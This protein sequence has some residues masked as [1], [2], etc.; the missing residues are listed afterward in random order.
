MSGFEDLFTNPSINVSNPTNMSSIF[1]NPTIDEI[2]NLLFNPVSNTTI[3]TQIDNSNE[4][5]KINTQTDEIITDS[6]GVGS[7]SPIDKTVS[8]VST[9]TVFNNTDAPTNANTDQQPTPVN[10]QSTDTDTGVDLSLRF[11]KK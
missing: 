7:I 6:K 1:G 10:K 11:P 4:S 9:A 5:R 3:E 2:K 8:T